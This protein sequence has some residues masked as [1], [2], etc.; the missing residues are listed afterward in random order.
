MTEAVGAQSPGWVL[1]LGRAR[2]VYQGCCRSQARVLPRTGEGAV[3]PWTSPWALDALGQVS[4]PRD[5]SHL[6][7]ATL[8]LNLRRPRPIRT[9]CGRV[10]NSAALTRGWLQRPAPHCLQLTPWGAPG[11]RGRT[12]VQADSP[13][14]STE[15]PD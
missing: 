7:A 12:W 6:L 10:H 4:G 5:C 2:S 15:A 1:L 3:C 11:Q 14:W 13:L 9:Q 8:C